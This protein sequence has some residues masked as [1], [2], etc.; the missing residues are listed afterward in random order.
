MKSDAI[1]IPSQDFDIEQI[2]NS[3]QCFRIRKVSSDTWNVSAFGH[4]LNVRKNGAG[5]HILECSTDEYRE[6]W[7]DYFDA[8]CDYGAIKD[9]IRAARD[10]YLIAAVDYGYGIRILRQDLWETIV[11]FIISQQN[12]IPRIKRIISKLCDGVNFP[13]P[14]TLAKYSEADLEAIGLGYRAKYLVEIS[15]AVLS[16]ELSLSELKK[17]NY[18]DAV[19]CLKQFN[20]IGDKVANCIALYGLHKTESFPIDVWMKRIINNRY[21]GHFNTDRFTGY[22]GV[23]Q[24]YMFFYERHLSGK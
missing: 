19:S 24:Q 8:Q 1:K 12:N 11:T 7:Q 3:G 2:A 15:R 21:S 14:E 4:T 13:D 9:S 5:E 20:G 16:G 17:M 6:I 23:V 18:A 10:P 22:A